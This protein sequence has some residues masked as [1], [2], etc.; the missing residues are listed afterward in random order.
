MGAQLHD[1]KRLKPIFATIVV[2]AALVLV[3]SALT[4]PVAASS[5]VNIFPPN[6]K[7]YN[8]TYA[9]HAKNF[10]I[11]N[12]AIPANDNPINDATGEKCANGQ[13][14]TNS[15]VF[16]LAYN[17]GGKS[18][19][20]CNVPAGKALLIPVM[21]VEKS[22]K[23]YP[24]ASVDELDQS[25]KKDQDS[26]NS[27]YLK[28]GDKEYSYQDLLKYRTHTDAF[29]VTFPDKGIFG[30]LEGGSSKAVADGF[31]ILTEPLKNGTYP[32]HFKS[33]LICPDPDC[34]D[35]N[36]VQDIQY[37]IVAE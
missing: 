35:P 25:A 24:G 15:T 12:L 27:L 14:N 28:I 2:C 9:D 36:F 20:I 7:P 21:Q 34:S 33:S 11:W 23:E 32:V 16:Y 8:L 10:W 19:R 17:N 26:V 22:D 5:S 18:E 6:S 37:T 29:D 31:Y 1:T 13:T 4:L 30:V 3:F